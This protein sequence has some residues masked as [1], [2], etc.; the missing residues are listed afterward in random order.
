MLSNKD[1]QGYWLIAGVI[2]AV[3]VVLGF[4]VTLDRAPKPNTDN[5][6]G[7]PVANTVVLLDYSEQVPL[8]TRDEI[9]A[10][11]MAHVRE[12]VKVN[13]RVSVFTISALSKQEL[14]PV[15]TLCRPP[16][17]GNRMVENVNLIRKKFQDNF[18][19]PLRQT[20]AVAPG[21]SPESPIAQ[22]L[23]DISLSQ[24]LRGPTNT[25]LVFSDMLENTPRFTLYRCV[26]PSSA[27]TRFKESRL[28]AQQ[29]PHFQNTAVV[30]NLVPRLN[31]SKDTL[32]CRDVLWP[33]FFGDNEGTNAKLDVDYLPGGAPMS[34]A[35]AAEVK[36]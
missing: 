34:T 5:C 20:L 21:D 32:Q 29:R 18:E 2:A 31:Q 15:I 12:H 8:Q 10:R 13:E 1:R 22:A 30:L 9:V 27:V 11:T 17:E 19:K 28:G 14:K 23:I 3:V 36:R 16:E 24:Y 33:W 4:K 7:D 26:S 35:P 6:V 25:L